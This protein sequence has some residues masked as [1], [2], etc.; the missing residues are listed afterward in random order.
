MVFYIALL[1]FIALVACQPGMPTTLTP[2]AASMELLNFW[3]E[4]TGTLTSGTDVEQWRFVGQ[5][6]DA[7]ILRAIAQSGDVTITLQT[8]DGVT[9]AQG[10]RLEITLPVT[11]IYI[12]L[13]Q[14]TQE[15]ISDY[16]LGLGY[17]DRPNPTVPLFWT[18]PRLVESTRSIELLFKLLWAEIAESRV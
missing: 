18:S 6:G 8:A 10:A 12:V 5:A 15:G 1:L 3:E 7:I 13:V 16:E 4:A 9:L 11:G 14:L 2:T 17:T